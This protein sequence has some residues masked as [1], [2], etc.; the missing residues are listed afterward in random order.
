MADRIPIAIPRETVND[1]R[2]LI[3]SW[4]VA[5][6]AL[7]EQDQFICEVET[8]KAVMEI[9]APASG[10]LE[11][12]A[13]AGDEVLVGS[14]MAWVDPGSGAATPARPA[15]LDIPEA[16]APMA[17]LTAAARALAE[18]HGIDPASFTAGAL[19]RSSDVLR[20]AGKMP[21]DSD[22]EYPSTASGGVPVSWSDLPRRKR[23]EGRILR[24]G[25]A[26][27]VR[28]SVTIASRI[29]ELRSLMDHDLAP[30]ASGFNALLVFELAR[31]LNQHPVFNSVY[32]RGRIGRYS[33]VNIGWAIEGEQGLV[34]PV[35]HDADRKDLREI[36]AA[37]DDRL[38]AY[39]ESRLVPGDFAGATFTIS[40]LSARGVRFFEPLAGGGQ[41]AILGV[42]SEHGTPDGEV[43]HLTLA[44]DHQ[45]ATGSEAAAFLDQ[46]SRRLEVHASLR[47]EPNFCVLCQRDTNQLR[48]LKGILI[49][50]ELPR[51]YVCS[52]CLAGN[53]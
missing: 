31:V 18:Q 46:L 30:C 19:V 10:V 17:R 27:S 37:L 6:G 15:S 40:D 36:A 25:Q 13:R 42:G 14:A 23:L 49:R 1:D 28:S 48:T 35:I 24:D 47:P 9:C 11:Y 12:T 50:S 41:S 32:H 29:A 16:T 8:S 34:V 52:I 53:Q 21:P 2:V 39:L 3:L 33:R 44:F 20:K 22:G 26:G 5:S 7:V 51:G 4:K 38:E 45:L 43:L